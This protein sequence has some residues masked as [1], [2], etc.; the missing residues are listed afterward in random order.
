MDPRNATMYFLIY[1]P[2]LPETSLALR[3]APTA[4]YRPWQT[5]LVRG[6]A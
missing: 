5:L 4:V 3:A 6:F 1:G 2:N